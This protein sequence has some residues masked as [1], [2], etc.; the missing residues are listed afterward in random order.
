MFMRRPAYLGEDSGSQ[1]IAGESPR[2]LEQ[3]WNNPKI[4]SQTVSHWLPHFPNSKL[5]TQLEL[6]ARVGIGELSP[7]KQGENSGFCWQFKHIRFNRIIPFLTLLVSVLV[8]VKKERIPK[9][10]TFG[11]GLGWRK[12]QDHDW[13]LNR[14]RF[15]R[16][17]FWAAVAVIGRS[18]PRCGARRNCHCRQ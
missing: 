16:A 15:S 6:E 7:R 18:N 1:A 4:V 3:F 11:A 13:R 12:A 10:W 9:V 2:I 5:H 14:G 17:I 8:S